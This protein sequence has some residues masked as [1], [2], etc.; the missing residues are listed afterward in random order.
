MHKNVPYYKIILIFYYIPARLYIKV[1]RKM[2]KTKNRIWGG[3]G[4]PGHC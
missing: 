4:A 1:D 2:L 3:G